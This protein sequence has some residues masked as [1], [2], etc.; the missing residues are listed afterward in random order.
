MHR[1]I[2]NERTPNPLVNCFLQKFTIPSGGIG[3][4]ERSGKSWRA[5]VLS[6]KDSGNTTRIFTPSRSDIK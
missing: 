1:S 5:I 3:A 4:I 2:P 6:Y